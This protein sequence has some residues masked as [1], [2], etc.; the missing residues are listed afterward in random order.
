MR[1]RRAKIRIMRVVP[2]TIIHLIRHGDAL[3]D[4]TTAFSGAAGYDDL[5]LST[6]GQRQA[7]ALAARLARATTLAAIVSSPT[8]R[9]VET[10]R[11]VGDA[12]GLDVTVDTRVREMDLGN[13]SFPADLD[14][15]Q[16]AAAI[17]ER[18]AMLAEIALRDGSWAAVPD[19]ESASAVRARFAS[20]IVEI[21]RA[22]PDAHVAVVSHAGSINAYLAEVVGTTR[23]FFFPAGNTSLSSVRI[24]GTRRLIL[25]LNDTAH[26][27]AGAP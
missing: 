4:E 27:E 6:T 11:A 2:R 13:E 20:S 17:R 8:R 19:A 9:A 12:C 7:R 1:G 26:L 21:V 3:P 14:A 25:R 16:R 5:G 24:S 15:P 22:H 10:A 18:L 23:D